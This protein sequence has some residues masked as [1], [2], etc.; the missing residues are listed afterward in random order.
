M[1]FARALFAASM[2]VVCVGCASDDTSDA[3][4]SGESPG[5]GL[6][7]NLDD[8]C[9][10]EDDYCDGDLDTRVEWG[11]CVAVPDNACMSDTECPDGFACD[12]SRLSGGRTFGVCFEACFGDLQCE[13]GFNCDAPDVFTAGRCNPMP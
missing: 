9:P 12:L 13:T 10:G 3:N 2:A 1:V 4:G 6:S 8:G 7:C 5:T 11:V